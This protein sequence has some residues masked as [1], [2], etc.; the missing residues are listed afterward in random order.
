MEERIYCM[1]LQLHKFI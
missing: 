1:H